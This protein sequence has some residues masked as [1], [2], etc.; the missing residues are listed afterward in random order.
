MDYA[1]DRQLFKKSAPSDVPRVF[2]RH[3]T[4]L[5]RPALKAAN[6][7]SR[8]VWG[9][10]HMRPVYSQYGA[11]GGASVPGRVVLVVG[12]TVD[13]DG[14]GAGRWGV[15][16]CNP[17]ASSLVRHCHLKMLDVC[18]CKHIRTGQEPLHSGTNTNRCGRPYRAAETAPHRLGCQGSVGPVPFPLDTDNIIKPIQDALARLVFEDNV[19]VT[20]VRSHRR[21][22]T[23]MFDLARSLAHLILGS[24]WLMSV[25]KEMGKPL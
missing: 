7:E 10:I 1:Q 13:G 3:R 19:L 14:V 16:G 22:R 12:V 23:G 25:L 21:I 8:P 2:L 20:N 9:P 24:T 15:V 6:I 5:G 18:A 4:S 17:N 11:I